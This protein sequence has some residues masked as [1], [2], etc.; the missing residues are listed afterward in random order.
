MIENSTQDHVILCGDFNLALDPTMDTQNYLNIN[1]PKSSF[2]HTR[3]DKKS[4]ISRYLQ[5]F[6]S[7]QNQILMAKKKTQLSR[8]D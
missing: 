4:A 5:K 7:K 3:F 2:G 6:K 8:P 1:N